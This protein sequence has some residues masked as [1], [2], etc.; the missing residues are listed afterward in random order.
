MHSLQEAI[1]SRPSA[2]VFNQQ[3]KEMVSRVLELST[4]PI[5]A[6][7]TARLDLEIDRESVV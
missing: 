1:V 7:M 4:L 5:K 6:V 2:Y 3:E